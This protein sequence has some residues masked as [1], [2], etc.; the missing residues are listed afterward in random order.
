MES[1]LEYVRKAL[2]KNINLVVKKLIGKRQNMVY[3]WFVQEDGVGHIL[4][5]SLTMLNKLLNSDP[6]ILF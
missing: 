3:T 6:V 1:V 5:K 2:F 4:K